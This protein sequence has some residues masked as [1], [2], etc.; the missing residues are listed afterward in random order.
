MAMDYPTD[1]LIPKH[2]VCSSLRQRPAWASTAAQ[3]LESD[4]RRWRETY[5]G[6]HDLSLTVPH[7][8]FEDH[9]VFRLLLICP[10]DIANPHTLDRI[11]DLHRLRNGRNAA[12]IFL[13]NQ[14]HQDDEPQPH[15]QP[16]MPAFM[17]LHITLQRENTPLP[18]LPLPTPADLHSTLQTFVAAAASASASSSVPP[19]WPP[20]IEAARDLL[21]HCCV[22]GNRGASNDGNSNSNSIG[23]NGSSMNC[24]GDSAGLASPAPLSGRAVELLTTGGWFMG[25]RELLAAGVGTEEGR[26]LGWG[27]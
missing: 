13:L 12:L 18:I 27:V 5:L 24:G 10:D 15:S 9:D 20:P 3:L 19:P 23:S 4:G 6:T 7:A 8:Y 14:N 17:A 11:R 2:L 25:F 22:A 21:P 26:R 16:A 1:E